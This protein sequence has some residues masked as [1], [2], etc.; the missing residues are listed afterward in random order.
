VLVIRSERQSLLSLG[1]LSNRP[2]LAAVLVTAA[3]QMAAIYAAPLNRLLATQ[4]LGAAHLALCLAASAVIVVAVEAEK[5][6]KRS[7]GPA[8]RPARLAARSLCC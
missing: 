3:V 1:L 6:A 4:P 7:A 2:L 8:S 5:W